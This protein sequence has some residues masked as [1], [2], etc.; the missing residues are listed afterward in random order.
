MEGYFF[1]PLF[2]VC[3]SADAAT[4]LTAAGVFGSLNSFPAVEATLGDVFSLLGF[5]V[6]IWIS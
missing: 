4:R 5:F 3:V 6:A 1:L 2:A